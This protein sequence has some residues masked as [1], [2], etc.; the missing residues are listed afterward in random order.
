MSRSILRIPIFSTLSLLLLAAVIVLW[1]RSPRHADL[2][3]F[4]TPAGHLAGLASERNGLLLCATE[5]PFGSEMGLSAQTMSA[6]REEFG[7]V[8]DLLFDPSNEKWHFLGFHTASGTVSTWNWKYSALIIPYWALIIPLT[9]LPLTASRRLIIRHRRKRRGQCLACGYDLRQ[10]PERCPEC[11]RPAAALRGIQSPT[12]SAPGRILSWAAMSAILVASAAVEIRGRH[13]AM[14]ISTDPPERAVFERRIGQVDLREVNI[15]E[16]I[17][18]LG[19]AARTPIQASKSLVKSSEDQPRARIAL[20]DVQLDIALQLAC[21]PSISSGAEP[22]QL[23][24]TGD[25]IHVTPQSSVPQI[26]RCYPVGWLLHS[27]QAELDR[28]DDQELHSPPIPPWRGAIFA[29]FSARPK[30]WI[31]RNASTE[32]RN[33]ICS[34]V[35]SDDWQRNRGQVGGL[36]V[37]AG[38]LWVL[39]TQEG[40]AAV[41]MLL[42]MLESPDQPSTAP[43]VQDTH[44]DLYQVIP[45]LKLESTTLEKAIETLREQTHANIVVYWDDLERLGAKRDA[46]I[47]LHLWNVH[48]KRALNVLLTLSGLDDPTITPWAVEDGV[49]IVGS[50]GRLHGGPEVVR[51][52]DVRDLIDKFCAESRLPSST[53]QPASNA[54]SGGGSHANTALTFEDVSQDLAHLIQDIVAT[55]SWKD[56]GGNVGS[57]RELAGRLIITQTPTNHR[58]IVNLLRILRSGGSKEG[59]DLSG[60]PH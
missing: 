11:G 58:K 38:R 21:E 24:T 41:R 7:P 50:P 39:Q 40:H 56:N 13:A 14:I 18:A 60:E 3:T 55:D 9:I 5:I 16:A 8:H 35:R 27:M 51:I 10:S 17:S 44:D 46:P 22:I 53:T 29:N 37:V 36:C 42:A 32:L 33:L 25:T 34:T 23:W 57:I 4:Y 2:V 45:E 12:R 28:A 52:Y 1:C 31:R 26:A 54:T 15:D 19:R 48:L 6:T 20:N 43:A 47:E 59:T 49:I 30:R